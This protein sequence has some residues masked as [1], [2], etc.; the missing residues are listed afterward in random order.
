MD[1]VEDVGLDAVVEH[2][3]AGGVAGQ[4]VAH[5]VVEQAVGRADPGRALGDEHP[6]AVVEVD[7]VPGRR[8]R[9]GAGGGSQAVGPVGGEAVGVGGDR[10]G[11]AVDVQA[12][13]VAVD[14]V[15]GQA[16]AQGVVYVDPGQLVVVDLVAVQGGVVGALEHGDAVPGVGVGLVPADGGVRAADGQDHPV[17]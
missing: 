14:D 16:E 8:D 3:R 6:G 4:P 7:Q 1:A 12:D 5:L 9:A 15:A 13:V 10:P 2:G 17:R 11:A